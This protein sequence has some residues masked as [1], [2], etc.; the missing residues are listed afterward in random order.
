[1]AKKKFKKTTM[2]VAP[3]T[4]EFTAPTSKLG[5][6]VYKQDTSNAATQNIEVTEALSNH[7]GM[8]T[9]TMACF[10]AASMISLVEPY[11]KEPPVPEPWEE[12]KDMQGVMVKNEDGTA[13]QADKNPALFGMEIA[14]YSDAVKLIRKK[15]D[16]WLDIRAKIFHLVLQ[17][18]PPELRELYHTMLA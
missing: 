14:L 18:S 8:T 7:V 12:T 9:I 4:K 10:G 6:Y 3:P 16:E 17:H 1:M 2:A 5:N 15:R 13:K 11:L